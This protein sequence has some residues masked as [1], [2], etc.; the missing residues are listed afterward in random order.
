MNPR[1]D[2]TSYKEQISFVGDMLGHDFRYAINS[3]KLEK[4]MGFS[5]ES[6]L[7]NGITK[8]I[9]WYLKNLNWLLSKHNLD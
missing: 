3:E 6:D 1:S 2:S 9:D 4:E 8:T 7:E 5:I